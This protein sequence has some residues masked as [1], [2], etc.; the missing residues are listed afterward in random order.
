MARIFSPK[1]MVME[2]VPN[3][4]RAKTKSGTAVVDIIRQE[5]ENMGYHVYYDVLTASDYGVPQKRQR[6]VLIATKQVL[7]RPFPL[8]THFVEGDILNHPVG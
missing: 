3:I 5:F 1:V 7:E 6:F 2:N 4:I 8:K